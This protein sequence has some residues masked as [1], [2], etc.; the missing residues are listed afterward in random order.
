MLHGAVQPV[1]STVKDAPGGLLVIDCPA[2]AAKFAVAPTGPFITTSKEYVCPPGLK[3][4]NWYPVF[5]V[6]VTQKEA[7]ALYQ[8]LPGAM[9]PV[10]AGLTDDVK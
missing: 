10:P 1:P 3:D 8:P 2:K 4:E 5:G 6:S 7:P 9:V